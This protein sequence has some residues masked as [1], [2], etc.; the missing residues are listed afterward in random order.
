ML[1]RLVG[2]RNVMGQ[3]M[4]LESDFGDIKDFNGLKFNT[5]IT[6]KAGGQTMQEVHFDKVELDVPIDEKIFNKG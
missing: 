6:V 5:S 3:D 1:T 2:T 4:E